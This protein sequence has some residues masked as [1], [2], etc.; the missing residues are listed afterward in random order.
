MKVDSFDNTLIC[1][2]EDLQ[3]VL[4]YFKENRRMPEYIE[5]FVL[6]IIFIKIFGESIELETADEYLERLPLSFAQKTLRDIKTMFTRNKKVLYKQNYLSYLLYYLP[7]NV[8]K[9]WK[10][11]LDLQLKSALKPQMRILDIGTGPGS[12]PLGIIEYYKTLAESFPEMTLS[13][14]FVFIEGEQEFLNIADELIKMMENILPLNLTVTVESAICEKVEAESDFIALSKFD[15]ITMSNFLTAN[16]NENENQKNAVSIVNLFKDNLENDGSLIIIEPGK[17]A[18]CIA[19]KKIRNELFQKK[20]FNIFSPCIG[21]WEEK[22]TYDC[23]CFNMVRSF[24]K[25]PRIYQYLIS[26]GLS[27]DDWSNVPFNYLV[28]RKDNLK[29]YSL[30]KN[31]QSY[32]KLINLN[33][34]IGRTVNIIARL[35]TV[36]DKGE[37]LSFSLCDGSCSFSEDDSKAIWVN[38]FKEQLKQNGIIIPLISAEKITMKKVFVKLNHVTINLELNNDSRIIIEY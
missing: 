34:K 17:K 18:S 23:I 14:S 31:S 20:V 27:K 35:R 32:T 10:P 13:L 29:K 19:L 21:I 12:V 28:L 5:K 1:E 33:E 7:G 26:N 25:L 30:T 38:V 11:L 22:I 16:E 2:N 8:F 3:T 4:S 6:K 9:V 36:I 24:W 37:I 15:L